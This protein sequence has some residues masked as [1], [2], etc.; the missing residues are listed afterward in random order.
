MRKFLTALLASAALPCAAADISVKGNNVLI[1]G[2]IE[3]DDFAQ[4][5]SKT[6]QYDKQM[7]VVLHSQG[8][9]IG[10]ALSV[11]R[12]IR[13]R[14]W[15]TDC[16][17]VCKS[18]AALIWLAGTNRYKT[19]NAVIAVHSPSDTRKAR[20]D[21]ASIRPD[22]PIGSREALTN[23][24]IAQYLRELGYSQSVAE[25]A[26]ASREP[27]TLTDPVAKR[28]GIKVIIAPP[29]VPKKTFAGVDLSKRPDLAKILSGPAV[30][31]TP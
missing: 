17:Q 6:A 31:H 18:A 10:A 20:P 19:A 2:V 9:M 21:G 16:E 28:L 29:R 22:I 11:G 5:E 15:D 25:F 26:T 12:M 24:R 14:S 23:L 3:A 7:T 8:G 27:V 30:Q 13:Q 1:L 4:F